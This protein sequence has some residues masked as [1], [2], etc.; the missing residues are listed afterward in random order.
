MKAAQDALNN[1]KSALDAVTEGVREVECDGTIG[2]VGYGGM[3]DERGVLALDAA[4]MTGCGRVGAVM[5]LEG[6]HSAIDVARLVLEHSPHSLL[7]DVGAVTFATKH[8]LAPVHEN[9]RLTPHAT[10]RYAQ[11]SGARSEGRK[12]T[13][14]VGILVRDESGALVVGAASSGAEFKAHGRVGDTPIMGCGL[15]AENGAGCAAA[16]G[17]GD[18]MVRHC[19]A[20]RVVDAMSGGMTATEACMSVLRRVVVVDTECQAAVVAMD[21][22]GHV[23]AATTHR[24]FFVVSWNQQDGF[25]VL[26]A[27]A[28]SEV[29]WI[30]SGV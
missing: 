3:P 13:D 1:G 26:E 17:D 22:H 19:I 20:V 21:K 29:A 15:Y 7:V 11:W 18:K 28:L 30:H 14:T 8:G 4:V 2:S 24:G 12:H 23:G 9:E 25:R 5:A 10:R 16:T 6:R 27:E